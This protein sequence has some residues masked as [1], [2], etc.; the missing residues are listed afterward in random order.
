E[1]LVGQKK[2]REGAL[3][4]ERVG[5]NEREAHRISVVRQLETVALDGRRGEREGLGMAV[6]L[7]QRPDSIR[8]RRDHPVGRES[9]L[10]DRRLEV[11]VGL[12]EERPRSLGVALELVDPAVEVFAAL[13]EFGDARGEK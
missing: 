10:G 2:L 9:L 7:D 5:S 3:G 1:T 6:K 13:P 11:L 4:V 12:L 8:D